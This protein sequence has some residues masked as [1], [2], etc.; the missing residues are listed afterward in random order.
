MYRHGGYHFC[1][2]LSASFTAGQRCAHTSCLKMQQNSVGSFLRRRTRVS[3]DVLCVFLTQ[4]NGHLSLFSQEP[5]KERSKQH[6]VTPTH[7]R[8][9][10][11]TEA[12][13]TRP[14]LRKICFGHSEE[15][16]RI[17]NEEVQGRSRCHTDT[18]YF[19][20]GEMVQL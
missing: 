14:V 10:L 18:V 6:C 8:P 9:S 17:R 7:G 3:P 16:L 2:Q 19:L 1:L 4:P 12:E 15:S 13:K 5:G 11:Q 20:P